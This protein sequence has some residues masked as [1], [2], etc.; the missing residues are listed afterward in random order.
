MLTLRE[1]QSAFAQS[2]AGNAP[3]RLLQLVDGRGSDPAALLAIY[4]NNVV[5]RLTDTLSGAFPVVYRLVDRGFFDYAVDA[6]LHQ[7]LPTS[8]CLSEYGSDFPL[9]LAG[10][11]PAAELEYLADVARLEW[12]IH[13]LRHAAAPAPIAIAA[14]AAMPGDPSLFRLQLSTAVQFIASSYSIDQIWIAHQEDKAWDGL[15]LRDRAAFLQIDGAT[16]LRI[17]HLSPS[18]WEF[19][20]RLAAHET[21]ETAI[22]TALTVSADFDP[23]SELAALFAD[24]LVVGLI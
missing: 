10:F 8:G 20:S 22:A 15:Q 14:L 21:L 24:D 18:T 4:R 5:T 16:T 2:V 11:A 17:V 19:R 12:A 13:E 6:F 9:F 23:P 3:D 1:L 7:H